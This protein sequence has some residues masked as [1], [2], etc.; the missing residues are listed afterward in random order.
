[1]GPDFWEEQAHKRN[2]MSDGRYVCLT[3]ILRQEKVYD[4]NS[5]EQYIHTMSTEVAQA[6]ERA[7]GASN[8]SAS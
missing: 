3:E 4:L 5:G 2:I 1:M 6:A 7:R 8:A